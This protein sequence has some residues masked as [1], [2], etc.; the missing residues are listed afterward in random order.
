MGKLIKVGIKKP[1]EELEIVKVVD[2]YEERCKLTNSHYIEYVDMSNIISDGINLVINEVGKWHYM[3]NVKGFE[4]NF[5][6][7]NGDFIVGTI[8]FVKYD[9]ENDEYLDLD[10]NDIHLINEYLQEQEIPENEFTKWLDLFLEEKGINL[11]E[12]VTIANKFTVMS[13]QLENIVNILKKHQDLHN[14]FKSE[15]VKIDFNNGSIKDYLLFVA[16][17]YHFN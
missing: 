16:K 7:P 14:T 9:C 13:L 8:L 15:L 3:D 12:F 2:S 6:L 10:A 5:N 17:A 4:R 11:K 1:N